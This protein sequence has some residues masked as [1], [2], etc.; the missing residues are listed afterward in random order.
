MRNKLR[1]W[2][3]ACL[4]V[5]PLGIAQAAEKKAEIDGTSPDMWGVGE[6]TKPN[7]VRGAWLKDSRFAMFVHWGLY[8]ELGGK[9]ND[10]TYYGI[11]EWI[12][13]RAKIP[14][15]EYEQVA[16]RFN[17]TG[18]DA[19]EWVKLAKERH[20]SSATSPNANCERCVHGSCCTGHTSPMASP[21]PK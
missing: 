2:T 14:V 21:G 8:S 5:L 7:P 12:M 17:P 11:A 10:K 4:L 15:A 9:W 3:L 6:G 19:G 16:G 20:T 18:F 13:N 1:Y